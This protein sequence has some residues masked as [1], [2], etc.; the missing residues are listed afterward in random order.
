M[1]PHLAPSAMAIPLAGSWALAP[2]APFHLLG[3]QHRASVHGPTACDV[4]GIIVPFPREGNRG[5]VGLSSTQMGPQSGPLS[6]AHH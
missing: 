4:R 3:A 5:S 6:H 1:I 2:G